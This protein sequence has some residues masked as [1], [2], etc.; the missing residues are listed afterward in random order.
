MYLF[1]YLFLYLLPFLFID[2]HEKVQESIL[3]YVILYK[4]VIKKKTVFIY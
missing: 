4:F 3:F 2:Y 1:I